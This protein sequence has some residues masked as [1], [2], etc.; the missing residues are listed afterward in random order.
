MKAYLSEAVLVQ[1]SRAKPGSKPGGSTYSQGEPAMGRREVAC[2]A[3]QGGWRLGRHGGP[4]SEGC[5]KSVGLAP[6]TSLPVA[7]SAERAR[8]P[9]TVARAIIS[10]QRCSCFTGE[11]PRRRGSLS[12]VTALYKA[13]PKGERDAPV[14]VTPSQRR[15]LWGC[16]QRQSTSVSLPLRTK[17]R[18]NLR[19]FGGASGFMGKVSQTSTATKWLAG[20]S[21]QQTGL[22]LRNILPR[23]ASVRPNSS[24]HVL[25]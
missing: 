8:L 7:A 6:S 4:T 16:Q 14:T 22:S 25:R 9:V 17:E 21:S 2:P 18:Q 15:C 13:L 20:T 1:N 10:E 5:V 24:C 23:P 12:L 3:G 11:V 19:Q